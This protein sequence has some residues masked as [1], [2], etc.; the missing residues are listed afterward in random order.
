MRLRIV[1]QVVLASIAFG[2]ALAAYVPFT[3]LGGLADDA[4][5]ALRV[6]MFGPRDMSEASVVVVAL[7]ER[8]VDDPM[9]A[10]TPRALMSPV[11][12]ELAERALGAGAEK[13][14][15]DFIMAFDG[16]DLTVDGE[17][18][19]A[20][21]DAPFLRLLRTEGRAGRVVIGRSQ[22]LLPA[23]RFRA[24]AGE[25]GLAFVDVDADA[26]GVAR[27]VASRFATVEGE[28]ARTLFGALTGAPGGSGA[29]I[30]PPGPLIGLPSISAVD[31]LAC[32]DPAALRELF[33]GKIVLVG[34]TLP[35]EDRF[36]TPDRFMDVAP[37][38]SPAT[39]PCAFAPP[40]IDAREGGSPGV[41]LHAAAV[42]AVRSGW[43]LAPAPLVVV[44]AA[45][46]VAAAIAGLAGLTL[47]PWLAAFVAAAIG[48]I[49]FGG[50]AAAQEAGY[51]FPAARAGFAALVGF[52]AGWTGRLLFLDRR[53]RALR[54]S[55]GRYVAPA[56]VER[57][58][59]QERLPEL[60]GEQRDVS[61]MFADLSGFTALSEQ[62]DGRTL[63]KTVNRYLSLIA[64]EV[65]ASGGYV[66]KFIGDAVMALWNA[67][68]DLE[69][70]ERAAV[71]AAVSI[72]KNVEAAAAV[73][74]ARGRP[75]F[76]IKIGVNAG[77]V[78]VGNVGDA[79]RMNY[80][81]VG[82]TV[83]IA[84]RMEGL[85]SKLNTPVV[86]GETCA[87][88]AEDLFAMLEVA[89]IGVKGR[90]EPVAVFAPYAEA[91]RARFPA[92]GDALNAY[93]SRRFEDAGAMWRALAEIDWSGKDLSLAMAG[94]ADLAAAAPP[95]DDW[96]GAVVM[97]AK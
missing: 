83:N 77:P 39:G 13:V 85:P 4:A 23:R 14:G 93:R 37:R 72:R 3:A 43:A 56:V 33:E 58:L 12:A 79:N 81:A 96:T 86:I 67:P 41:Y 66:D 2:A 21:Y 30:T 69:R 49:G 27:R 62:V 59:A 16:G 10:G 87:R 90:D 94:F 28:D 53:A 26:D 11:W 97:D 68:A 57:I 92:Y 54:A 52:I 70:H 36:R 22:R 64:Q 82:D 34:G 31:L 95:P 76:R 78:V 89:S 75:N 73:D 84:A 47:S 42:D 19:L 20:R 65:E 25:A 46:A 9:L 5:A 8:S 15:F 91:D 38:P 48:V 45:A 63:T 32:D 40:D 74:V 51:L 24:M 6:D 7:D 80:T 88:A 71:Q 44:A 55:F 1:L 60:D 50:A 35:G 17:R 18:P 29:A 61:V